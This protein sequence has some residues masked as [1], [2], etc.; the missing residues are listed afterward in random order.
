MKTMHWKRIRTLTNSLVPR[1]IFKLS[2][3]KLYNRNYWKKQKLGDAH[4]YDKYTQDRPQAS[5]LL[6][7]V[8]SRV[9]KTEEILD[10]G[11]NCGYYLQ[12]LKRLGFTRLTGVDISKVAIEYGKKEFDLQG[13]ELDVGSFEDTL[14][15][16]VEQER[17][18]D[19]IFSMGATIELVHPS[20]NIIKYLALLSGKYVVLF[21]SEWGHA[22]PRCYEY[23]FQQHGFLMVKCIRPYDGSL[24]QNSDVASI[25]SLLVFQKL[26]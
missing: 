10:L 15:E 23:E 21:I 6:A 2:L 7:E 24:V 18:F 5:Y 22:T 9:G 17:Q 3:R 25:I 11:C 26:P 19:L 16:L 14:P 4:G 1:W 12:A 13:V 20:F 8:E